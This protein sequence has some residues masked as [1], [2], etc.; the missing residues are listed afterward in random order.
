MNKILVVAPHPDDET[1][2]CG[3]TLLKNKLEGA[4]LY[5]LMMTKMVDNCHTNND[6]A[7]KR[8]LE[9]SKVA[10]AYGFKKIMVLDFPPAELD[11]IPIKTIIEKISEFV[12]EI[13]PNE[14][15]LSFPRDAHSDHKVAF[16]ACVSVTKWFRYPSVTKVYAYETQSETDFDISP[17]SSGFKP[18]TFVD[19][20]QTIQ[21]KIEI[22]EIYE[23]EFLHHPF[24]RSSLAIKALGKVR[25]IASGFE[26]AEAFMLL[27]HRI[28][29]I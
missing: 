2:G 24:P 4:E 19:I 25:G 21:Q 29:K 16:D 1:L 17:D 13:E 26:H 20:S 7:N 5:W 10:E 14:I 12:T 27:K 11:T 8:Q 22:A 3:G 9:I 28:Y 6:K 23:G 15:Y 18:N